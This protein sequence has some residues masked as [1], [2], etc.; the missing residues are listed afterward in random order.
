TIVQI[1]DSACGVMSNASYEVG[2]AVLRPDGT[3]FQ[4][5]A[6]TCGT[7]HTA[8]YNS[9]TGSWTA[10]PDF[11]DVNVSIADGPASIEPNGKVLMM[12]SVN[13]APPATFYEWDGTNLTSIPGPPNAP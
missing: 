7:G 2:P 12:G 13:E 11:P 6:N 4:T 5:G 9:G 3:V 1:W 8:I 10:G